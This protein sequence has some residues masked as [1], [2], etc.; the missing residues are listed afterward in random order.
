[1]SKINYLYIFVI[2][3]A[4]YCLF[5]IKVEVQDLG[6]QF[7]N[8]NNQLEKE[9]SDLS[10]LKAEF[11][12]LT[13]PKLLKALANKHLALSEINAQQIHR[14]PLVYDISQ[15]TAI[16]Q[17]IDKPEIAFGTNTKRTRWRYKQPRNRTNIHTI[18]HKGY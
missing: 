4:G 1:M 17:K 3:A 10:I 9:R 15:T 13:S 2:I 12:Y 14:D 16:A 6:Y 18:S 8:V 11:A 7:A 5:A